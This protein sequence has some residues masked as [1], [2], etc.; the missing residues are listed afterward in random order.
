MRGS[1]SAPALPSSA[2]H[3]RRRL[4]PRLRL[5]LRALLLQQL[6]HQAR[7]AV[8]HRVVGVSQQLVR[9]AHVGQRQLAARRVEGGV[10]EAGDAAP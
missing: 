3:L 7:R 6:C 5:H 2:P 8:A 10:G 9:A 1:P 4:A